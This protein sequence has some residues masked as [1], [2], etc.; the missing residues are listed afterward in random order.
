M[1]CILV[2]G[3]AW[4]P[5]RLEGGKEMILIFFLEIFLKAEPSE[6]KRRGTVGPDGAE[7]AP[8]SNGLILPLQIFIINR[9]KDL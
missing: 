8:C 3:S 5:C 7:T 4:D 9:N 1:P 2:V 6:M